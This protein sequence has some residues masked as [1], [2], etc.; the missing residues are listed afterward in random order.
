[1]TRAR[2]ILCVALFALT[3]LYACWFARDGQWVAL[4][5][6]A[7]PPLA[8]ALACLRGGARAAFWAG[9]LALLWFSHGVMVGWTRAPERGFA[10]VAVALSVAIVLAASV[11]GLR[12]RFGGRARPS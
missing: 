1:M 5:V 4:A 2:G 7:L 10:L 6:F 3:A 8:C 12:R 11:P 9:V